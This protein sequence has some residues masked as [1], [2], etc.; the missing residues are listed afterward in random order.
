[1]NV[2]TRDANEGVCQVEGEK[3][4]EER[5]KLNEAAFVDV[6]WKENK[7]DHVNSLPPFSSHFTSSLIRAW[8]CASR[9]R[10]EDYRNGKMMNE[11]LQG[12]LIASLCHGKVPEISCSEAAL[13]P[14]Q[15]KE[16]R[17]FVHLKMRHSSS[18]LT[19]DVIGT[20]ESVEQM[21]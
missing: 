20:R 15:G 9:Y 8:N 17:R 12:T 6:T 21:Q 2:E 10:P 13:L 5:K 7:R 11:S 16:R 3:K 4:E 1:M 14:E 18:R 19:S